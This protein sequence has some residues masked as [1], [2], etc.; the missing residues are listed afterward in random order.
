MRWMK[1]VG[2]L[3]TLVLIVSCITTWTIIKSKNIVITGFDALEVGLGRPGYLHFLLSFFFVLFTFIP[4]IWAK[5][6]NLVVTALNL[7]WAIRNWF[8]V[9]ACSWGECPEKYISLYL[10]IPASLIMLASALF[11]DYDLKRRLIK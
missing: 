2:L 5:R 1:W 10:L 4:R 6:F 11:P 7:A 8:V 9:S 3:A